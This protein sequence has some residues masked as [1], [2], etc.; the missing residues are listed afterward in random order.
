MK[1]NAVKDNKDI[2][3]K[4]SKCESE[5]LATDNYCQN[6]GNKLIKE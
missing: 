2:N 5:N 4:C 1:K 6:C 3:L